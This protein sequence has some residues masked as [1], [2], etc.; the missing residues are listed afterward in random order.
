MLP[1]FTGLG[2]VRDGRVR[3]QSGSWYDQDWWRRWI[4]QHAAPKTP[5]TR[6][7]EGI[8]PFLGTI[9]APNNV[10]ALVDYPKRKKVFE[11]DEEAK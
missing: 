10:P 6:S 5:C 1:Y 3:L 11:V 4:F 7:R 8:Y 2:L 9:D